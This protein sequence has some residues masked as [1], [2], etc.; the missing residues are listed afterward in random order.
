MVVLRGK[1]PMQ[2]NS[3]YGLGMLAAP[4]FHNFLR[5]GCWRKFSRGVFIASH[6]ADLH[7]AGKN[8]AR[9]PILHHLSSELVMKT[10]SSITKIEQRYS[11]FIP[12]PAWRR[13]IHA[14][15][16]ARPAVI[17]TKR[18]YSARPQK[19][20]FGLLDKIQQAR[21]MGNTSRIG[22]RKMDF[23]VVNMLCGR[24]LCAG[25]SNI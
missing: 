18:R 22:V 2:A 5:D 12:K 17:G 3:P 4:K 24:F 25:V 1:L 8:R 10:S 23:S 13:V 15:A 9:V 21:E 7:F 19:I 20:V 11:Y 16:H 14:Q 6:I